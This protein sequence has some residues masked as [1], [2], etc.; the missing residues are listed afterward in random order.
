[1]QTASRA[2][3]NRTSSLQRLGGVQ[4]ALVFLAA[5]AAAALACAPAPRPGTGWRVGLT[6]TTYSHFRMTRSNAP[7]FSEGSHVFINIKH[8]SHLIEITTCSFQV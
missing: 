2:R 4:C 1:M 6:T 3:G 7:A 8:S 5:A